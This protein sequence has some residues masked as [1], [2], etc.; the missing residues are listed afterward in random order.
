MHVQG[1]NDMLI[2]QMSGRERIWLA[3][4]NAIASNP[5]LGVGPGLWSEWFGTHYLT[6]DFIFDDM[7]GNI[8]T[9]NPLTLDGQAHNLFLT[10]GAEMGV[11]SIALLLAVF[12]LWY[13]RSLA[14]YHSLSNG[15]ARDL[16]RG[17][18]AS[19]S[20]LFFF[21]IFENGPIIGTAREGEVIF[22]TMIMAIPFAIEKRHAQLAEDYRS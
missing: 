13:Q 16:V 22:I 19:F 8:F 20:G 10:K 14:I 21:C 7:R 9:L 12:G 3:A 4:V 5:V 17:C 18:L 11:L 2:Y 6:V 1:F 15:W